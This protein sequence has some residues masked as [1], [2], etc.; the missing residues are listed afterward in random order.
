MR[1]LIDDK[2]FKTLFFLF[3]KPKLLWPAERRDYVMCLNTSSTLISFYNDIRKKI[4]V[5]IVI[6]CQKWRFK[7]LFLILS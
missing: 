3:Y 6:F 7:S 1:M 4:E 2:R 5:H